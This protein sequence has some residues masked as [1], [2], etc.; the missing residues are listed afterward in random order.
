MVGILHEIAFFVKL[1]SL[2]AWSKAQKMYSL[3]SLNFLSMKNI[4]LDHA[5]SF[6]KKI[7]GLSNNV[8]SVVEF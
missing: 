4:K 6:F 8:S 1:H 5:L 7:L 3:S 2:A